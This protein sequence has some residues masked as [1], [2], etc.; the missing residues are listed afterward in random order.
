MAVETTGQYLGYVKP[1][2]GEPIIRM[3][4][5]VRE[6]GT[7]MGCDGFGRARGSYIEVVLD[8]KSLSNVFLL[9]LCLEDYSVLPRYFLSA[10]SIFA[11]LSFTI[12]RGNL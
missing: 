8:I 9:R 10:S 11:L 6:A 2:F 1:W 12:E 4:Y 5:A 3:I 7:E